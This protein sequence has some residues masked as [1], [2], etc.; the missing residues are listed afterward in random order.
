METSKSDGLTIDAVQTV[1]APKMSN[2]G[3]TGEKN[4]ED[5]APVATGI[6]AH[7]KPKSLD[8]PF[9]ARHGYSEATVLLNFTDHWTQRTRQGW[10]G[11][12]A[13]H[14]NE[15]SDGDKTRTSG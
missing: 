12:H 14:V 10:H 4:T 6:D 11:N 2:D 1:D 5:I 8:E 7:P 3:M 13:I 15:A 9:K